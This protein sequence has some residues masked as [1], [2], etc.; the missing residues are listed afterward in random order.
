MFLKA[1][2]LFAVVALVGACE[3]TS[4]DAA[5]SSTS[6][7]EGSGSASTTTAGS[8]MSGSGSVTRESVLPVNEALVDVGDRVYFGYDQYSLDPKARTTLEQQ[9]ALL[10]KHPATNIVIQG[11]ADE[12]GTREYNLALGARRASSTKDYLVALGISPT[13]IRTVSFGEER[14][15]VV[16]SN[17]AA[18]AQNRRA[19]TVIATGGVGS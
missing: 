9:A 10:R 12:R 18:F 8:G 4:E 14:P 19:V 1:A 2:C 5:T 13:R 15:A 7:A 11:H 3:T 16:G 17:E 6:G